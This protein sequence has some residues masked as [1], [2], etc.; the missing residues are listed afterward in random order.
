[1]KDIQGSYSE[2]FADPHHWAEHRVT[3]GDAV[4][5]MESIVR[6]KTPGQLFDT[7]SPGIGSAVSREM[8]LEFLPGDN[9]I[10]TSA[11]CVVE[12]RIAATDEDTGETTWSTW[13]PM[14]TFFIDSR[15]YDE[16]GDVLKIHCYD[17]ML[18]TEYVYLDKHL[19]QDNA[20]SWPMSA[21]TVFQNI[22]GD[23][24]ATGIMGI[25][26]RIPATWRISYPSNSTAR[27][28]LR[29]IAV[30]MGG[31][32]IIDDYGNLACPELNQSATVAQDLGLNVGSLSRGVDSASFTRVRIT[33]ITGVDGVTEY[34][35]GDD[36]GLT[37]EGE[38]PW[39]TQAIADSVLAKVK[40]WVY[41]PFTASEA[42]LEPAVELGDTVQI[43]GWKS[44]VA[45]LDRTF[46]KMCDATLSAPDDEE[47]NHEFPYVYTGYKGN[48]ELKQVEQEI[49]RV[50][51]DVKGVSADLED[52][53]SSVASMSSKR[54][55]KLDF[56]SF[57]SGSFTETLEN[58]A[59]PTITYDVDF[60]GSGRPVKLTCS[61]GHTMDIIW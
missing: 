52:F 60:D 10:P 55:V 44:I 38:C 58:S 23:I 18:K 19:D 17:T 42:L 4:Y 29:Q 33:G 61:D 24:G 20:E 37:I 12:T 27:D 25:I 13:I 45:K 16:T 35:A 36:T 39:G 22:A 1:M 32:F 48:H 40:G 50:D 2:I 9:T 56:T 28:I 34:T 5:G 47:L 59:D 54:T 49:A 6:L 8:E 26:Q 53:K 43:N 7:G 31:N 15:T 21:R 30:A 57:D 14:G 41:R 51:T 46:D 3:I 11:K